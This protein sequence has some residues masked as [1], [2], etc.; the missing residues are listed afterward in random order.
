MADRALRALE[1]EMTYRQRVFAGAGEGVDNLDAY[2][3]TNPTEPMPRL[4]LVVDE[5]AMLAKEYPDVLS[6]LVS[7][8][9]VGDHL[10]Q[11]HRRAEEA[12]ALQPG[13]C[14]QTH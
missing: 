10:R 14:E 12:E 4:L 1:A 8:G 2:L 7:V 6:S 3:A 9:A 11:E 5:F 13:A